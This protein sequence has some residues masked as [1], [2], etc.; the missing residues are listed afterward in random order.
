MRKRFVIVGVIVWAGLVAGAQPLQTWVRAH[1]EDLARSDPAQVAARFASDAGQAVLGSP[2]AGFYYGAEAIERFWATFFAALGGVEELRPLM[3]PKAI[4]EANLAYAKVELRTA[5]GPVV[6]H[7]YHTFDEEG[8]IRAADYAVVGLEVGGP[9]VDG[10]IS[11]G[12]YERTV[13]EARSGVVFSWR[14]GLVV[15]FGALRSPGTGWV[16]VGFDPMNR[17]QGA[18]FIIAAVTPAGLVIED[19][20]GTSPTSHR[21]DRRG[22]IL[23]AAGTRVDGGTLVEF[24]IPLDSKDPEDKPLV[25]G[26]TYT[27]LLAHHRSSASFTV[28]H[29]ARGSASITLEN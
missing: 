3:E 21:R 8:R 19:H 22:D 14:N 11:E 5:R 15:L 18:N 1:W 10:T 28:Q 27:V 17:M 26:K 16:S 24:V 29:T 12:E 25:P 4:P 20:F 13:Q 6:L 7:H 23:E 2:W 9:V